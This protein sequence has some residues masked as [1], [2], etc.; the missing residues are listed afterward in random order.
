MP[1][2]F[3]AVLQN[4]RS[5]AIQD[6][7][8]PGR[9]LLPMNLPIALQHDFQQA[10]QLQGQQVQEL[11]GE[12]VRLQQQ[13]VERE[14][15]IRQEARRLLQQRELLDI[16]E[17]MV[18]E[19]PEVLRKK[20]REGPPAMRFIAVQVIS[21]RRL[22]LETDLIEVL[23]DS[24]Q[25]IRQV[26]REA[27]VHICRGTDFGPIPGASQTG[28]TRSIEKRQHWLALQH[29]DSPQTPAVAVTT[30]EDK[31]DPAKAV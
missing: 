15:Q 11:Q 9:P 8:R 31:L 1:E 23:K 10:Q 18:N 5:R 26:S 30:K 21:K 6:L 12:Q 4:V 7:F 14:R 20:L 24:D 29:S 16:A 25:T 13:Q 28:I 22:P 2:C 27:L 17:K 3:R 19:D